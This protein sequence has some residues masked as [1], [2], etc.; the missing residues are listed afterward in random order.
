MPFI[1]LI[2]GG[3]TSFLQ[4]MQQQVR[5]EAVFS[6]CSGYARGSLTVHILFCFSIVSTGYA[7]PTHSGLPLRLLFS[8]CSIFTK[9]YCRYTAYVLHRQQLPAYRSAVLQLRCRV[10]LL[11]MYPCFGVEYSPNILVGPPRPTVTTALR[12]FEFRW[13]LPDVNRGE[14]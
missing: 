4:R 3:Q 6:S 13:I 9:L 5:A 10:L 7:P 12:R 11:N 14:T 1:V 2:V 8:T